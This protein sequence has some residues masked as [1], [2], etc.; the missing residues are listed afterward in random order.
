MRSI[1]FPMP[2]PA[3]IAEA[4]YTTNKYT[5]QVEEL[6]KLPDGTFQAYKGLVVSSSPPQYGGTAPYTVNN[7]PYQTPVNLVAQHIN[8]TGL[9][10]AY[11][12]VNG[13]A[14]TT[15]QAD[16][17]FPMP[18]AP[19]PGEAIIAAAVY[20]PN[21]Y[22]L[23]VTSTPPTGLSIGGTTGDG[24]MTDYTVSS[25]AYG[26]PVNLVAPTPD[27][28]GY[29]FEYWT[30][31]SVLQGFDVRSI[32]FPMSQPAAIAEAV[33]TTNKFTVNVS[34]LATLEDGSTVALKSLSIGSGIGGEGAPTPYSR[35]VA[36]EG[37]VN[38]VAPVT[39]PTG[40][41]FA[42]WTVNG[43]P[44]T[45]GKNITF[46]MPA[47][48]VTAVATYTTNLY[49][50]TVESSP[51]TGLSITSTVEYGTEVD[52]VAPPVVGY[53]FVDWKLGKK[54]YQ[55]QSLTFAMPAT[56]LTAT[57]EYT[58]NTKGPR[59][60]SMLPTVSSAG[61]IADPAGT[62]TVQSTPPTGLNIGSST[63]DGGI[64]NYAVSSVAQGT[65]VNLQAPATDPAG[66]SFSQWMVNGVA[67]PAGQKAI[68]FAMTSNATAVAQYISNSYYTLTV[69]STP[70]TGLS[71][72]SGTGNSGTTN[73]YTQVSVASGTGVNL[74]APA[75]DPPGYSFLQWTVNGT[76]Q[77]AGLK[78]ITFTTAADTTAVA[79]YNTPVEAAEAAPADA[80][81]GPQA[82]PSACTLTVQS[83]P[84]AGVIITSSTADGGLTNYTVSG[85]E[86]GTSV[87]LQAPTT[88]PVGYTFLQW[89]VDGV[90]Q[91]AGRKA[92]AF[93]VSSAVT[94][95]AQ[96]TANI[97]TLTVQAT[98]PNGVVIASNTGDGGTTNYTA[99]GIAYGTI[100]NLTAPATDPVGY[101]FSQWMLNGTAQTGGPQSI[102][103]AVSAD[104]KTITFAMS[105][106]IT[107][108]AQYTLNA[109][110]P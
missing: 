104:L 86:S 38:L 37:T 40:Y 45:T 63:G 28:V 53:T 42:Y 109:P 91:T 8:P 22:P 66:Y 98:P 72:A 58:A 25:V 81:T 19:S 23:T 24:E 74:Q 100:V 51:A 107:A 79:Q 93:T 10:F 46:P 82:T 11:W 56:D 108:V 26:S 44:Q 92:I 69:Q 14:Q 101:T 6:S 35:S 32:T 70:P 71:I 31:N 34:A 84:P 103:F 33:Y 83:T 21:N 49:T 4:V 96:Y 89:T 68:T 73:Y 80:P 94:A 76:A 48:T 106:G 90:A 88:D 65:S 17:T 67:Q 75:T 78:N 55:E 47:T 18:A 3:A 57:A 13:V 54:L 99:P 15:G 97:C 61:P 102:A 64:T 59:D 85:I 1:T 29:T 41:T 77:T 95:V 62:L 87:T 27:P 7:I 43:T 52:L 9:T 12:S 60:Q 30:V 110:A 16:I 20:T 5:L 105:A 2:E 39:D 50:L 36:Y